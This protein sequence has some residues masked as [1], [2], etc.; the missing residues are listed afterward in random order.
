MIL[1]HAGEDTFFSKIVKIQT[2][3][4]IFHFIQNHFEDLQW[5]FKTQM[6]LG[7]QL[8]FTILLNIKY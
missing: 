1:H 5:P 8:F 6:F 2:S 3:V 4:K 7:V